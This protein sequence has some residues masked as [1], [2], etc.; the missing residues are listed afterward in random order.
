MFSNNILD[1]IASDTKMW[2][3]ILR[4]SEKFL[5][6][7]SIARDNIDDRG[8]MGKIFGDVVKAEKR[9]PDGVWMNLFGAREWKAKKGDKSNTESKGQGSAGSASLH[10]RIAELRQWGKNVSEWVNMASSFSR[11]L[12]EMVEDGF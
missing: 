7:Q 3:V 5:T 9:E 4:Q 8:G 6:M 12:D 1:M 2:I 11:R 10:E